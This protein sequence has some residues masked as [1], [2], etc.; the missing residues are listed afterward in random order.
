MK[1]HSRLYAIISYI[2]W[3]GFL[4][5]LLARDKE[6]TL[7]RQHMNQA[8][9]INIIE[10]IGTFL[11]RLGG[12]FAVIG[13]IVDIAVLIFV[14]MGIVRAARRS[15]EPLPIIGGIHLFD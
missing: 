4:V 13:E 7:V 11:T 12:I 1:R 9:V 3:I 5:A 6:D 8:L 15:E 2:T 14:V 10:T